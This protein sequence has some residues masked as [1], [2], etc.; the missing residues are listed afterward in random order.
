[1]FLNTKQV[2]ALAKSA[3]PVKT[4]TDRTQKG[5]ANKNKTRRSVVYMFYN[6]A[7]ADALYSQ[8]QNTFRALQIQNTLKRTSSDSNMWTHTSGGEYVRVIAEIV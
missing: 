5:P 2:R 8:L 4:Y 1:M 6:P 7:E 3:T